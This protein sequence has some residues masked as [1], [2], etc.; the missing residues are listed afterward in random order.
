MYYFPFSPPLPR[1]KEDKE[2]GRRCFCKRIL[3]DYV[4]SKDGS[5]SNIIEN[6]PGKTYECEF[7]GARG[8]QRECVR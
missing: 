5:P 1:G 6:T 7:L 8:C 2:V 3:G 4:K